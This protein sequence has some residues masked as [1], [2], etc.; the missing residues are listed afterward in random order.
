MV[1]EEDEADKETAAWVEVGKMKIARN[2]HGMT[3]VDEQF[4]LQYCEP[5]TDIVQI[6][7]IMLLNINRFEFDSILAIYPLIYIM[8]W[9]YSTLLKI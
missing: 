9:K 4:V 5:W 8:I 3:A 6:L 1:W 2:F 7:F